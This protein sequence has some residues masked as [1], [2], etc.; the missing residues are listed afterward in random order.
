MKFEDIKVGGLYFMAPKEFLIIQDI[1][2]VVKYKSVH[3]D[4][5][6]GKEKLSIEHRDIDVERFKSRLV[7][8]LKTYNQIRQYDKNFE[9]FLITFI[10]RLSR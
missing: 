7:E 9:T 4:L 10:F 3:L 1:G 2:S 8:H 6:T 5:S